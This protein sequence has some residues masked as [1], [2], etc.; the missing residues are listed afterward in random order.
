KATSENGRVVF[1]D[2]KQGEY[3]IEEVE[4]PLGYLITN[5]V[6][7]TVKPNKVTTAEM[8]DTQIKGRVEITKIDKETGE[9][10]SGA[11]FEMVKADNNEVVEKMTTG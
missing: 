8:V 10:I 9:P 6:N 7:V 4:A 2:I 1:N 11:E 5:P 3:I